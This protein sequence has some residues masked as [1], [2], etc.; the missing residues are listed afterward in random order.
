[1]AYSLPGEKYPHEPVLNLSMDFIIRPSVEVFNYN[2]HD[3]D[4]KMGRGLCK[5]G[6][7]TTLFKLLPTFPPDLNQ[8]EKKRAEMSYPFSFRRYNS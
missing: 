5:L 3:P 1:L 8:E 4:L 2:T 7:D 6:E